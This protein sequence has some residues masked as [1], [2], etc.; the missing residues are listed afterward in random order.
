LTRIDLRDD[1]GVVG[2]SEAVPFGVLVFIVGALI[3]T[4]LWG[5]IDAKM[6]A[7]N[8]AREYV[9]AIAEAPNGGQGVADGQA[10]ARAAIASLGRDPSE[11]VLLAPEYPETAGQWR[12]CAQV[13]ATVRYPV[14][15]INVPI[16]SVATGPTVTVTASRTEVVDP[17]RSTAGS[18]ES[19]WASAC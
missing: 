11:L 1:R 5:V 16:L 15:L 12:R 8:A 3:V 18:Q 6:A 19:E 14:S 10:A 17:Y 9:H 2:G 4:N 7:N 13:V